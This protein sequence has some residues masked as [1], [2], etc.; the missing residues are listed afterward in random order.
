[1]TKLEIVLYNLSN[2]MVKLSCPKRYKT[3]IQGTIDCF[4]IDELLPEKIHFK[5]KVD[6][7][8]II[9]AFN[10]PYKFDS[11]DDKFIFYV[12]D[13]EYVFELIK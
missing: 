10:K 13:I 12:D 11:C 1:M 9:H 5:I 2:K 8:E 7:K 3:P 6:D 4:W